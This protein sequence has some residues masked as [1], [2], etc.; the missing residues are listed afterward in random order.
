MPSTGQGRGCRQDLR[1]L[2]AQDLNPSWDKGL[3]MPTSA[4]AFEV[5]LGATVRGRLGVCARPGRPPRAAPTAAAAPDRWARR[6]H[7]SPRLP[8][9]A[10]GR[11]RR[12][13]GSSGGLLRWSVRVTDNHARAPAGA[14]PSFM[15]AM[16]VRMAMAQLPAGRT[17]ASFE[18]PGG[19]WRRPAAPPDRQRSGLMQRQPA[20]PQ[21]NAAV[22]PPLSPARVRRGGG[23]RDPPGRGC[24][25]GE[26]QHSL[27]GPLLPRLA[28]RPSPGG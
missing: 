9:G 22:P 1:F 18:G 17:P 13:P 4:G 19:S 28:P 8:S 2:D 10:P 7:C 27:N 26:L 20:E 3:R 23:R 24:P 14:R 16:T 25:A 11:T 5:P 15:L 12:A 21:G 6:P